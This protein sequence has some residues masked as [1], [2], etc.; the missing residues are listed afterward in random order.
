MPRKA[1]LSAVQQAALT[2]LP[3]KLYDRTKD[4]I[5]I[6]EVERIQLY[7][8]GPIYDGR[9]EH[10]Q[11]MARQESPRITKLYDR[12]KGE[13]ALSEVERIRL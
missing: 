12:T 11:Q 9:L 10:V 7:S 3:T 1:V 13:I 2:A 5:T 6:G 8:N 4:E